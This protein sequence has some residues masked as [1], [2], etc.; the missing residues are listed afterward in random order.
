M[1]D[2]RLPFGTSVANNTCQVEWFIFVS[3]F[4]SFLCLMNC[5]LLLH[6]LFI[7]LTEK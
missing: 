6:T 5:P 2:H 4:N 7:S 3:E 1:C